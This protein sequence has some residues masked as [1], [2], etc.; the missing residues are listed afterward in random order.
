[1]DWASAS[2]IARA[3]ADGERSA[4]AVTEAALARIK[5]LNPKL[6]AFTDVIAD[7]ARA[8]A[9]AL[10]QAAREGQ[11]LGALA[12]VPF[13]VKNLFDVEGLPT[14]AGSKI[15]R[16]H[17]PG[18]ARR[19]A[20][21]AAGGGRRGA[22]RRAQ[23]GR[24]RLRLHRRERPR[25]RLAQSARSDAH[26][27]RLVRRLRRRGGGRPRAARARLRH[28]R[29][30]PRAVV[31]LRHLRAQAD[32]RAAVARAHVSV[33]REPRPSRPVRAHRQGPRARL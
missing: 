11:P 2:E 30:D 21:R 3:V 23:H 31:V 12:G 28:Q 4:L 8:K 25:R 17:A 9:R 14:R 22:G 16:S 32:L 18:R 20:D 15:N 6:N 5:S 19:D 1:M 7:R 26:D 13:A 24:I 33:R 29:L 27:R 10:D